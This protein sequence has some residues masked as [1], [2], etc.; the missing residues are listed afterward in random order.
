MFDYIKRY[1][2]LIGKLNCWLSNIFFFLMFKENFKVL[3]LIV[4]F[5]IYLFESFIFFFFER[6]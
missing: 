3:I 2:F 5:E 4:R 6:I 1:F